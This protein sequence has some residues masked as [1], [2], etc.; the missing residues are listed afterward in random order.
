VLVALFVV[1]GRD[2]K[3]EQEP[4]RIAAEPAFEAA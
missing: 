4:E 2:L 1:R 3:Q